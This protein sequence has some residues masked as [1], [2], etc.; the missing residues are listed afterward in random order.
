MLGRLE[1]PPPRPSQLAPVA[2]AL[3]AVVL[4]CMEK[5]A[6]RRFQT[7]KAF[8][9][10]LREVVGSKKVEPE[11]TAR[12]AAIFVEIRIAD[13]ADAE[14]DE[15]LD[16]MHA[17]LLR[18]IATA[19]R[20]RP[21]PRLHRRLDTLLRRLADTA[22]A[23]WAETTQDQIWALRRPRTLI[24]SPCSCTADTIP[25]LGL[26]DSRTESVGIM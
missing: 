18:L 14:S 23:R 25:G 11:V 16:L 20:R 17:D 10:A 12:G 5:T 22:A 6:E 19:P 4:R 1:A 8:V 21:S 2:P 24:T 7:V 13:G 9:E 26:K 15:L 3:D